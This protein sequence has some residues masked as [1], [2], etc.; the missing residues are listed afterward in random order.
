[1]TLAPV[2]S[3]RHQGL[4]WEAAGITTSK[5]KL[6]RG[7]GVAVFLLPMWLQF[8][9]EAS[10]PSRQ[11]VTHAEEE[12]GSLEG[13]LASIRARLADAGARLTEIRQTI[14]RDQSEIQRI[15][16]G[17]IKRQ[18]AVVDVAQELYK[19]GGAGA[20]E[21]VL[22]SDSVSDL[23]TRIKYL[24]SSG[25]EHQADLERLAADR[26]LLQERLDELHA[27]RGEAADMLSEIRSLAQTIATKV[28]A[29]RSEVASLKDERHEALLRAQEEAAA[30]ETQVVAV[31]QP[32]SPPPPTPGGVNWDAIAQCESGGNWHL[33]GEY[34]GGLQFHPDTW[35][36]YGGGSYADYAWQAS[37]EQ[38]I[39]IAERVLAAQGG[40]AW[41]NCFQYG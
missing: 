35:L 29:Q 30:I 34:D 39:A 21:A 19:G 23:D 18:K 4:E 9:A 7:L 13:S 22:S 8:T 24:E 38:Q 5:L 31:T 27:A 17:I 3:G 10:A 6:L 2:V 28:A 20:V 32:P 36:G 16:R 40:S 1:M 14:A 12:L 37:R 25:S 33:D 26:K 11:E 15:A 41:P